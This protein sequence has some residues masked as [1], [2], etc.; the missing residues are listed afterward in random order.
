MFLELFFK[1]ELVGE[2]V[3]IHGFHGPYS[4]GKAKVNNFTFSL[5]INYDVLEFKIAMDDILGMNVR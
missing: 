4:F 3:N 2:R 1:V 5:F